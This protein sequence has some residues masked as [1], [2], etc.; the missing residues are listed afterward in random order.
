MEVSLTIQKFLKTLSLEKVANQ[1]DCLKLK[2][3]GKIQNQ[4]PT[5][6]SNGQILL[7]KESMPT[8]RL[9]QNMKESLNSQTPIEYNLLNKRKKWKQ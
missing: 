5:L 1:T 8:I 7:S 9:N 3:R 4:K 2:I 6:P